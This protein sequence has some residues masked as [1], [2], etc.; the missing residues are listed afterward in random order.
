MTERPDLDT[1]LM[2]PVGW[3]TLGDHVNALTA[4]AAND[5]KR[6]RTGLGP[7]DL[8]IGGVGRGEVLTIIGRSYSG[9]SVV[10]QNILHFNRHLPMIF[11]SLE[12]TA[13]FA[14]QRLYS[15][16]S[17]QPNREVMDA[18]EHGTVP[19]PMHMMPEDFRNHL[20]VDRSG[21][22]TGDMLEYIQQYGQVY[23]EPPAAA[24]VDY[25]E[26]VSGAKTSGD[27]FIGVDRV[28]TELKEL[29]KEADVPVIVVHQ[30][31]RTEPP[32]MPPG[33]DSARFGGFVE[34]DF[35]IGMWRPHL[36]PALPDWERMELQNQVYFSVLKNRARGQHNRS[37]IV[38]EL[39]ESLRL[40]PLGSP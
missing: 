6:V 30:C 36:D 13:L 31:N 40:V 5:Q 35:V 38:F 29:A 37:P 32:W 28:A 21:L 23:G 16:W 34:A 14:I 7:I 2:P 12:M 3:R 24:V 22:T 1:M 25:L 20:V 4:Y 33:M 26:I 10:A 39:E 11:F 17:G 18:I 19:D 15:I 27:G 8:L 9:K